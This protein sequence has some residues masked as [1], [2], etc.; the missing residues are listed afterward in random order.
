[1]SKK[2]KDTSVGPWAREKLNA[3]REYLGF[4][5]TVLKNQG[6]WLRGTLYVDAFAGPGLSRIRTKSKSPDP[7]G[8]FGLDPE[9]DSAETEF[10]KGSPRVALEIANPFTSYL[11]VD[12]DAQRFA[13]LRSLKSEYGETRRI[14]IQEGDANVALQTWLASG[15]DW[16]HNRGVVFLDPFGMQVPWSSIEALAKTKAL[17]VLINFPL[18]MAI[19]RLLIRS[20]EIPE[21]WQMSL[22]VF[23]GS[24]EWRQIV[25]EE[26]EDFFGTKTRKASDSGERLVEWYRSRLR[27]AFG[28]V[29]TARLIRNTRGNPL[30]FLIW[31]GPNATGLKGAE[32]ILRKGESVRGARVPPRRTK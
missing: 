16:Q 21:G 32:H 26:Q 25:Y 22:D 29:S 31:A 15:I 3:L 12:R 7:P 6:H 24:P 1:M 28:H 8:L 30:Y 27:H 9:S 20:G 17:E 5:T 2:P 10:L 19:Q 14:E 23:F 4:Y 18:G 11:F 13:E